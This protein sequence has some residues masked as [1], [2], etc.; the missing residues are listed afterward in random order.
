MDLSATG[1]G[2]HALRHEALDRFEV[3]FLVSFLNATGGVI[4][5]LGKIAE[6]DRTTLY[7]L[8]RR[9]GFRKHPTTGKW[10]QILSAKT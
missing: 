4:N 7:R 2:Y 9:H 1:K 6:V 10:R 5:R 8:L 3:E